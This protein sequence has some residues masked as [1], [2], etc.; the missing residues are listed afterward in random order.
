MLLSYRSRHADNATS[1][2][3]CVVV[4]PEIDTELKHCFHH[5]LQKTTI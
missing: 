2:R 1:F 3:I 5:Y 4:G